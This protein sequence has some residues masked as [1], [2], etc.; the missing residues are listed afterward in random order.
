MKHVEQERARKLRAQG[1]S[2]I[3]ISTALKVAKSS[4]SVWVRN[5]ELTEIQKSVLREKGH[6]DDVVER[7]RQSRLNNER[8][9]REFVIQS[10]QKSIKTVSEKELKLIGAMLYWAEGGKTQRMVRFSNGDPEMIKLMMV[11]FIRICKVPQNKF[12]GYIHIHPHLDHK[13]AE[14]YWSTISGIDL[15]QFY[16]TYRKPNK[17]S[18]N[19]K[20]SLP[21][22][23]FDIYI[24]DTH[25]FLTIQ[26]W[27][28]G[29]ASAYV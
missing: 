13:K 23:V 21:Y 12:R 15:N 2:I 25:L 4:V 14:R 17:G 24:L 8:Q 5:V 27:V 29:I 3:Q 20:D 11:F 10:A 16:K 26:G 9:K 6:Y 19:K 1:Y 7:R 18:Q 28:R 22:G